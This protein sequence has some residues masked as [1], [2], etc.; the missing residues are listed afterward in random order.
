MARF[1]NWILFLPF[2][3]SL[4][5]AAWALPHQPARVP[6]HWNAAG[7]PDRWGSPAEALFFL[8]GALLFGALIVLAAG[9]AQATS[10]PLLNTVVLG[11]GL[12]ALGDVAAQAFGWDSFRVTMGSLGLLFMLMGPALAASEPSALNGPQLSRA[13]LRRLGQA[14]LGLGLLVLLASLLAPAGGWITGTLLTGTLAMLVLV[15]LGARRDRLR[16]QGS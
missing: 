8:P 3:S 5:L 4:A 7:Q 10:R 11:L 13:T 15:V 9:Q 2:A 12:M 1:P 16:R 6:V 14:W